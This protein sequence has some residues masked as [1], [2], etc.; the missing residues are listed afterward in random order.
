MVLQASQTFHHLSILIVD[1]KF[2]G[3]QP[4]PDRE[5]A[6]GEVSSVLG[7]AFLDNVSEPYQYYIGFND[8]F[9]ADADYDDFIVGVNFTPNAVP[10]PAALPLMASALALFGFGASRRRM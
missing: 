2:I 8:T 1:F 7:F 4:N 9:D 5:F 3:T 6:N 10:V